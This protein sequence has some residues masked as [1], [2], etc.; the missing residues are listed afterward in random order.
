MQSEQ[1]RKHLH[2]ALYI[3]PCCHHCNLIASNEVFY[4]ILEKRKYIQNKI[5]TK[6][7]NKL[8]TVL[9]DDEE[10]DELGYNMKSEVKKMLQ[11]RYLLESRIN[12][13]KPPSFSIPE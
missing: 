13:P 5:R 4:N 7:I 10:V 9:W 2:F 11:E 6:Y 3:V 12:Y 1:V 8:K